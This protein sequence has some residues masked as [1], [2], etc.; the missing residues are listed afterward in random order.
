M[1][2]SS[3]DPTGAAGLQQAQSGSPGGG[4]TVT[5]FA[6]QGTGPAPTISVVIPFYKTS[7]AELVADLIRHAAR[8]GGAVEIIVGDDGS[9]DHEPGEE[10]A[11]LLR[12]NSVPG[13]L[14]T[15]AR[16]AGRARVRNILAAAA[17]GEYL[18]Y[19][20]CDLIPGSPRFLDNYIDYCRERSPDI[21]YGGF[22]MAR[23][24]GHADPLPAYFG[25][26]SD[27]L[28]AER[29]RLDSAKHTFTNNLLVRRTV[30][31]GAPL[32]E[33][34]TGWGWEDV[35]WA[36]RAAEKWTI[37]HIDNPVINP[38]NS[39][40]E[41]L[42][43]KFGAS[44]ANFQLLA[45]RHPAAAA[46]YPLY[47]AS[48]IAYRVPLAGYAAPLLR[49]IA[50]DRLRVF[51]LPLRYHALKLYRACMYRTIFA[52]KDPS[53][54]AADGNWPSCATPAKAG[55][56]GGAGTEGLGALGDA[57]TNAAEPFAALAAAAM[58][59]L[60]IVYPPARRWRPRRA[61]PSNATGKES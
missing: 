9:P 45:R 29:R 59:L 35:E 12:A 47:R 61:R 17:R 13:A 26:R 31:L 4:V 8:F 51:P 43:A 5:R 36:L 33:R 41:E 3:D 57:S 40:A 50:V 27:C 14:L 7:P 56:F 39:S 38:G 23:P 52:S 42:V 55:G 25:R 30:M 11:S 22:E 21:V 53:G 20:D 24:A 2:Y 32:D 18:L 10:T 28:A 37:H 48:R 34:F 6:G 1:A 49:S 15:L 58:M 44:A 60:L 19:I 54:K 16:N 46:T